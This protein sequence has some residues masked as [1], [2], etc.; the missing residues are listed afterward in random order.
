MVL[1]RTSNIKKVSKTDIKP[2]AK[3]YLPTDLPISQRGVAPTNST[4]GLIAKARI[5]SDL[6]LE[7]ARRPGIG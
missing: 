3:F 1:K 4:E 2:E 5:F 7:L 6:D